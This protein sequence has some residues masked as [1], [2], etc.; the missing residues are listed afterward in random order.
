MRSEWVLCRAVAENGLRLERV[1]RSLMLVEIDGFSAT[2]GG[3]VDLSVEFNLVECARRKAA[4]VGALLDV[5]V[6]DGL[7][8]LPAG[9]D[10]C[11]D[12]VA[13]TVLTRLRSQGDGV[14]EFGMMTGMVRRVA[15]RP[16]RVCEVRV[17]AR[18]WST[19]LPA[20]DRH[21]ALASRR[22]LLPSSPDRLSLLEAERFGVGVTVDGVPVVEP[23]P[24]VQRWTPAGWLLTERVFARL[25]AKGRVPDY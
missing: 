23:E 7:M 2:V 21:A 3:S 9:F 12:D 17:H 10:V 1:R 25:L 4:G 15:V 11:A 6:L 8:V 13:P 14:V 16:L 18:S 19:G 20:L 22:L 24:F 5:D